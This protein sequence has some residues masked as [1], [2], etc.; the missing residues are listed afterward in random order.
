MSNRFGF[1]KYQY[2]F[3]SSWPQFPKAGVASDVAV[4]SQGL[5]YVSF[6]D[7]PYPE[8]RSG[9][10]LVFDKE[11]RYLRSWGE[12]LFTTPHG[13]WIGPD[14]EIFHVDAYGHMVNKFSP[15]GDVLLT[16]GTPG[17]YGPEGAP[18]RGPTRAVLSRSGEIFVSD[19]Y[20]QNR[21]HRFT[22]EG[23]LITSW[24]SGVA[25][26]GPGEFDLPHDVTVDKND[27]VYVM[28]RANNRCQIF[29]V[30]GQYQEE[31]PDIIVPN[32]AVINE[33]DV[34]H[35]AEGVPPAI[36]V[37]T[38]SGE[39]LGRWGEQGDGPGQFAGIPH[40][41]W[42]DAQGDVYVAQVGA[43]NALNRYTRV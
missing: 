32:D 2:E 34:M 6:R 14:D 31:W 13:I 12:E 33:E 40:G 5:A 3:V 42:M 23:E 29:N 1:G 17:E 35:I 19:G 36:L 4:D 10:I 28:D 22:A 43:D 16:L 41:L 24:G 9:A 26:T 15:D 39:V 11:G 38:L 27:R 25:G 30:D 7:A 20:R 21:V 18:F 37:T 8:T